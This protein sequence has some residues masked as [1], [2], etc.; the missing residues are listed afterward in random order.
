MT[1]TLYCPQRF[2]TLKF[3]VFTGSLSGTLLLNIATCTDFSRMNRKY[4]D[5]LKSLDFGSTLLR[6]ILRQ[7]KTE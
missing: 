5:D 3:S 2:G 7:V 4:E 6:V 1:I